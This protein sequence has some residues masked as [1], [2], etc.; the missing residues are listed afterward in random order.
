[1]A[2]VV[3]PRPISCALSN[4]REDRSIAVSDVVVAASAEFPRRGLN[5]EGGRDGAGHSPR[6]RAVVT[7]V[8]RYTVDGTTGGPA[9]LVN[10]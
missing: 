1:M 10:Y 9:R 6:K 7:S 2:Y 5:V 3:K 4:G 8:W